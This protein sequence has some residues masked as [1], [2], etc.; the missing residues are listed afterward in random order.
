MA[1]VVK[2][3]KDIQTMAKH[4]TDW[5]KRQVA[6]NLLKEIHKWQGYSARLDKTYLELHRWLTFIVDS[7]PKYPDNIPQ[8][9]V[10]AVGLVNAM[11]MPLDMKRDC[12]HGAKA[13]AERI[14]E[15]FTFLGIFGDDADQLWEE[16]FENKTIKKDN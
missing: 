12:S 7:Y 5:T 14:Y 3:I 16:I 13:H 15:Y 9:V 11:A 10:D 6:E 8:S 2:T 4:H 1:V